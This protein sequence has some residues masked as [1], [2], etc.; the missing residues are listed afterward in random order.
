[1]RAIFQ[2]FL[3][4]CKQ[5]DIPV[6]IAAGNVPMVHSLHEGLPQAFGTD[7]NNII[8][9]GAVRA[10]GTL[11]PNT[12]YHVA[13]KSGSMTLFAPGEQIHVLG[14]G[15]ALITNPNDSTGTGQAAAMVVGLT[16]SM[17]ELVLTLRSVWSCRLFVFSSKS[18][19]LP[20][21]RQWLAG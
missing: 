21:R 10:D 16:P 19:K 13:G 7:D 17:T 1:M 18:F 14:P 9:V 20:V 6:V 5:Q 12:A 3:D 4:W 15:G 8:T 2:R 11:W